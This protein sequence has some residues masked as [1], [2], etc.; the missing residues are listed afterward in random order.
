MMSEQSQ[1]GD[2]NPTALSSHA[3]A[4]R[5]IMFAIIAGLANLA[6][7]EATIQVLPPLVPVMLSVLA[8]TA[9]GFVVKYLLDKSYVFL[10]GYDG[11]VAELRK[12]FL[13]GFFSIATTLLFW[14]VELSFWYIWNTIEA[15]YIGAVG[16]LSIG[17]WL[18]YMLDRTW[19]FPQDRP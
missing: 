16:G 9:V 7:Q 19:V 3:I 1:R 2:A 15:K 8:G 18:K 11:H 14:A 5:Y 4:V 10:D 6:T 12:V 13:Y 17:N